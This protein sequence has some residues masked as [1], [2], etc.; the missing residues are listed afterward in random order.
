MS[1]Q[2]HP[3][4]TGQMNLSRDVVRA[5]V[6]ETVKETEGVASL[7]ALPVD[8]KGRVFYSRPP[9]SICISIASGTIHVSVAICAKMDTPVQGL[10]E[11][12]QRK[13]KAAVQNMTGLAVS[14]V[15]VYVTS[16]CADAA[17]EHGRSV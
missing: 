5:I 1:S 17:G 15:D 12:L 9:Q 13:I 4:T 8:W 6:E 14:R 2:E 7:T 10:C 16:L 11:L 3:K